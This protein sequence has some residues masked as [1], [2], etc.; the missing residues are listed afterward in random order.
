MD[1]EDRL[2]QVYLELEE[3]DERRLEMFLKLGMYFFITKEGMELNAKIE[4]LDFEAEYL[5]LLSNNV[6]MN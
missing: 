2:Y 5:E 3:L 4:T 6:T 1:I